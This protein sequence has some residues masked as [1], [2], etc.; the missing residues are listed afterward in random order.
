MGEVPLTLTELKTE[1][2]KDMLLITLEAFDVST[3]SSRPAITE[4][5]EKE[6]IGVAEEWRE[7]NAEEVQSIGS[8]ARR[9]LVK[10]PG[11]AGDALPAYR[12]ELSQEVRDIKDS[13]SLKGRYLATVLDDVMEQPHEN[14]EKCLR[15][16]V[17]FS[18]GE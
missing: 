17:A 13:L 3:E 6:L 18:N 1:F 5:P 8:L 9:V 4:A 7:N 10:L 12:H 15:A 11:D 14:A 16:M 2:G